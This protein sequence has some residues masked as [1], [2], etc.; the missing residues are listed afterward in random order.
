MKTI[1]NIFTIIVAVV[2]F[3]ACNNKD[4]EKTNDSSTVFKAGPYKD[5]A[6][7]TANPFD[8]VGRLHNEIL[9]EVLSNMTNDRTYDISEICNLTEQAALKNAELAPFANGFNN[10][11]DTVLIDNVMSDYKNYF[12]NI[13]PTLHLSTIARTEVQ[14]VLN[15]I[16]ENAYT[17]QE[18][19][20]TDFRTQICDYENSVINTTL[21]SANEKMAIL[22]FTST[23]RYSALFWYED[24]FSIFSSTKMP[25]WLA[26]LLCVAADALG[27]VAGASSSFGNPIAIVGCGSACSGI[28]AMIFENSNFVRY[29]T[30]PVMSIGYKTPQ[31]LPFSLN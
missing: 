27:G 25:K 15:F 6:M 2:M 19:I 31:L 29:E 5:I 17:E 11:I 14:K 1:I 24:N 20:Y 21:L 13:I 22:S 23:T 12:N 18:F 4:I 7:N 28:A 16:L 3:A 10:N 30:P 8:N 26:K 9:G